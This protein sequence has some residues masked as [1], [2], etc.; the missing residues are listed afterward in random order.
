L[1][2]ETAV[3]RSSDVQAQTKSNQTFVCGLI[4]LAK[5][6]LLCFSIRKDEDKR[7]RSAGKEALETESE[8]F[9]NGET[10]LEM[11]RKK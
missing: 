1:K 6:V 4:D 10:A 8:L 5:S 2:A 3:E 11:T 7:R 9:L